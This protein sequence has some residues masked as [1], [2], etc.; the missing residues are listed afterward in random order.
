MLR[1]L[2][3]FIIFCTYIH[4]SLKHIFLEFGM[5]NSVIKSIL[6]YGNRFPSNILFEVIDD[7]NLVFGH[8]SL[9][10][11]YLV[12]LFMLEVFGVWLRRLNH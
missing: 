1:V 6:I 7:V 11:L 9:S 5:V 3:L 4:D 12:S 2:I 8:F 10:G